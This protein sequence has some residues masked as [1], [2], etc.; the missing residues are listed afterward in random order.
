MDFK[1]KLE[2]SIEDACAAAGAN[3]SDV[4]PFH[5]VYWPQLIN[6]IDEC[7]AT[8]GDVQSLLESQKDFINFGVAKQLHP[9]PEA[10]CAAITAT[11]KP[12]ELLKINLFTTWLSNLIMKT[13]Q[14][15]K[16]DLIVA[17]IEKLKTDKKAMLQRI[18]TLQTTRK[19]LLQ[20]ELGA[21]G[22]KSLLASIERLEAVD[23]LHLKILTVKKEVAKGKFISVENRRDFVKNSELL[24]KEMAHSDELYGRVKDG[25]A[26]KQLRECV[27]GIQE[28]LNLQ[29]EC[30]DHIGVKSEELKNV[31]KARQTISQNEVQSRVRTELE[32]MR[33]LVKLCAKRMHL[34]SCSIL[35]PKDKFFT[36]AEIAKCFERIFDFDP[37]ILCNQRVSIHGKPSILIVPGN[38]VAVFDWKNNQFLVPLVCSDFMASIAS[39]VIEYRLDVDEDKAL[40]NSYQKLPENKTI[41][42]FVTIRNN[43]T[44]DYIKWMTSEYSGFKVLSKDVRQWFEHEIAPKR[45]DIYCPPLYQQFEMTTESLKQTTESIEQRLKESDQNNP[46]IEEDLWIGSILAYHTGKLAISYE[47]LTKLALR[48]PNHR[49]VHFNLGIIAHALM[50]K[51]EAIQAFAE[52]IKRNP[53]SWWAGA[54]MEHLR[55]LQTG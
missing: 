38:G 16:K 14:A 1:E 2:K 13:L 55:R 36:V 34:N 17:D 50:K 39:A 40:S 44:K 19:E 42:S 51:Q 21:G 18:D 28:L 6:G 11:Q 35:Q 7:I 27:S 46:M 5:G 12:F 48:N 31:E 33:D 4:S 8:H 52:F 23:S 3:P 54:A 32:G 43:L 15:D 53:Q 10:V 41:R 37:R 9:Q 25:E 29:V 45:N 49:F 22:N 20:S 24:S 26:K 30:Q 47:Y